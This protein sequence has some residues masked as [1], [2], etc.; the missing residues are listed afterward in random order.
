MHKVLSFEILTVVPS[1]VAIVGYW[2]AAAI[3]AEELRCAAL[4]KAVLFS[5]RMLISAKVNAT[6]WQAQRSFR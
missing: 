4:V 6:D 2:K 1:T 3:G 5:Q